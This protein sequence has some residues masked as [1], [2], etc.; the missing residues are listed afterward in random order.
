MNRINKYIIKLNTNSIY[1]Y[2]KILKKPVTVTPSGKIEVC[3][4]NKPYASQTWQ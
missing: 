1:A 4:N 3:G 2:S